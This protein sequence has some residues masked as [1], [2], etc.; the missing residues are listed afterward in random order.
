MFLNYNTA[1]I[2]E[3]DRQ[4][5]GGEKGD[6]CPQL[7]VRRESTHTYTKARMRAS[8]RTHPALP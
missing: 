6:R 7:I 2:T 3:L 8:A 1:A 4:L 5:W